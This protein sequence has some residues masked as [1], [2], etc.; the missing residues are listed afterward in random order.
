M[1]LAANLQATA[2][3]RA[4][5]LRAFSSKILGVRAGVDLVGLWGHFG[6]IMGGFRGVCG[7]L[8]SPH[9]QILHSHIAFKLSA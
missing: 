3:F 6:S 4:V 1:V 8:L 5:P 7:P 9:G 2:G